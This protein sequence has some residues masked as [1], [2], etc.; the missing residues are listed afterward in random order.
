MVVTDNL[1]PMKHVG[2]DI[3]SCGALQ[4]AFSTLAILCSHFVTFSIAT[5][6]YRFELT[7]GVGG[8]L[9]KRNGFVGLLKLGLILLRGI[10]ITSY[11]DLDVLTFDLLHGGFLIDV[12][13]PILVELGETSANI[14]NEELGQLLVGLNDEAKE[15]A[16][17]IV[18]YV[19]ELLFEREWFEV[20]PREILGL[21][22][23]HPIL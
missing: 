14:V 6:T 22:H 9:E 3:V 5:R 21:Q 1:D 7:Y 18:N 12:V 15:L 13:F 17:V 23:E 11:M 16:V 8:L 20:F 4:P 19:A 2:D 10:V